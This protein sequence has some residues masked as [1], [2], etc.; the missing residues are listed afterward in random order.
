MIET[1]E[2]RA[3]VESLVV[4]VKLTLKL[5]WQVKGEKNSSV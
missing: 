3:I 5:A 4:I 2:I 1:L